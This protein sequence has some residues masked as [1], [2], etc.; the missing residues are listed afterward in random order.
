MQGGD[1]WLK[2]KGKIGGKPAS[3]WW[4]IGGLIVTLCGLFYF[5]FKIGRFSC[6]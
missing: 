5:A 4:Y 6:N 3:D 2:Y 1:M